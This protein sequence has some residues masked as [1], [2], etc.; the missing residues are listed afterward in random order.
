M[1]PISYQSFIYVPWTDDTFGGSDR[2]IC[3]YLSNDRLDGCYREN[4]TLK[5]YTNI[6]YKIRFK[7]GFWDNFNGLSAFRKNL[8]NV[9]GVF[10]ALL[11]IV[12]ILVALL[13]GNKKRK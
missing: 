13:S 5:L 3:V 11:I 8:L 1:N 9:A 12:I 4:D 7:T 2:E 6:P 10:L